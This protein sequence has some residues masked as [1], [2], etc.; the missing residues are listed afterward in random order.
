LREI[1]IGSLDMFAV[2]NAAADKAVLILMVERAFRFE[3]GCDA[4]THLADGSHFSKIAIASSRSVMRW[5]GRSVMM[6]WP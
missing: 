3:Q 6:A 5:N 1:Y 4:Y 2:M